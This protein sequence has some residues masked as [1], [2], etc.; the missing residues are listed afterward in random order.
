MLTISFCFKSLKSINLSF[1]TRLLGAFDTLE[2]LPVPMCLTDDERSK[3]A[4][5][6]ECSR[7]MMINSFG[8][9]FITVNIYTLR[10][11]RL[12]DN[13]NGWLR[14]IVASLKSNKLL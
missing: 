2:S 13:E 12:C 6:I 1:D 5:Q 7:L 14:K 8:K 10:D 9:I 11:A 4:H 3:L